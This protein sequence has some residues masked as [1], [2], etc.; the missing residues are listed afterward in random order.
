KARAQSNA[1]ALKL[2]KHAYE[3]VPDVYGGSPR[4]VL[5][6]QRSR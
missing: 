5:D 1:E 6:A 4:A 2:D 3:V